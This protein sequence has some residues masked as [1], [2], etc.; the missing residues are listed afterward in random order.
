VSDARQDEGRPTA[1]WRNLG[2]RRAGARDPRRR[3][4]QA[5]IFSPEITR[6]ALPEDALEEGAPRGSRERQVLALLAE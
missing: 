3:A 2:A 6:E 5:L 4:G 1:T